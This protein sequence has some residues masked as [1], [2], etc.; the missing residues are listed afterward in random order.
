MKKKKKMMSEHA[1]LLLLPPPAAAVVAVAD[2][3]YVHLP[4]LPPP[5]PLARSKMVV[6]TCDLCVCIY[7][8]MFECM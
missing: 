6:M 7:I 4:L 5:R 8:Y 2:V 1:L 3:V